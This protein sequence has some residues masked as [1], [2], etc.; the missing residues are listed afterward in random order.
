MREHRTMKEAQAE[1]RR[2][3]QYADAASHDRAAE[4]ETQWKDH[5]DYE[6]D[7]AMIL[8]VQAGAR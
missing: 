3:R 1:C 5:P 8:R 4:I 6:S 2:L 7:A